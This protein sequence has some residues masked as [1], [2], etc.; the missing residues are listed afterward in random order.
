MPLGRGGAFL[1]LLDGEGYGACS[2]PVGPTG[3]FLVVPDGLGYGGEGGLLV[4]SFGLLV[5][6]EGMMIVMVELEASVYVIVWHSWLH[7][8]GAGTTVS[9]GVRGV[10]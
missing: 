4:G 9:C 6:C 3:G 5:D 2:P 8:G 1:L 7:F 10:M